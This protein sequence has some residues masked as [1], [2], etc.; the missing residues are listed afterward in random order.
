M[1]EFNNKY[2]SNQSEIM[3]DLDFQGDEM[4]NLLKDLKVV[5]KWLGGNNITIE[6]IQQLLKTLPKNKPIVILDVGC[7]DGEMLR[8]CS[9]F[10]Q[11]H[12]FTFICIGIDF[13]HNIL[14]LAEEKSRMY[15]NISFQNVDIFL[16][17]KL[18]PNCDI[19]LC[20]L[21]LHHFSNKEIERFLNVLITKSRLGI[22]VNDLHRNKWAF[23]LFKIV[24]TL[25]LKTNTAKHD[26]L[27]SIARGFKKQELET[28][29][30]NIHYQK[31][32]IHWRWAYRYQWILKKNV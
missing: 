13:N 3:D 11:K 14:A 26:G 17:E 15:S 30:K 9:D 25:F 28:I 18:V 7:G 4:K 6:G 29:S 32:T 27:V 16:G 10:A 24:S 20:T 31:S 8:I 12:N 1:I 19:A 22:V 5:N 23:N 2:R 21:F